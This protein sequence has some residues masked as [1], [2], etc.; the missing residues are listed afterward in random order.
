MATLPSSPEQNSRP[1]MSSLAGSHA[2]TLAMQDRGLGLTVHVP[3]YGQTWPESLASFDRDSSSW[4]TSQGLLDRGINRV[5]GDLAEIGFDAEWNV[6]PACAFGA[7]HPRE[8]VFIVAYPS[9]EWAR[10]LRRLE[11]S[12][13]STPKRHLHWA[14][15]EPPCER[16]VN[17][18]PLRV[19]RLTALGNAVVPQ[20]AEWIGRRIME[21]AA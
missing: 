18:V 11:C 20:V 17:G 5:L 1:S 21:S 9:G 4:K 16:V 15:A 2:K 10:Q 8:R 7:P 6:L 19:D 14:G 13:E 3:A 12:P